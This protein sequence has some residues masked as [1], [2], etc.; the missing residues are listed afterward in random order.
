[1]TPSAD[2]T[3]TLVNASCGSRTAMD[4]LMPLVY[5]ELRRLAGGQLSGERADHTLSATAL[6][7]E[8]YLRLIDQTRVNWQNRAHFF[9][10]ASLSIRRI[11]V[12]H[13]RARGRLRRGGGEHPVPLDEA[14]DVPGAFPDDRLLALD[15]ALALLAG[16]HPDAAEIVTL[17]FFGGLT[18]PEVAEV[19]GV[20]ASTVERQWRFAR[21]WLYRRLSEAP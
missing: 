2:V 9:A 16:E 14:L 4:R 21:A 12:D 10:I 13:A 11:L 7:H 5:D 18:V 15:E 8:A 20:S 1:M 17:R 6:A 19:R 3:E